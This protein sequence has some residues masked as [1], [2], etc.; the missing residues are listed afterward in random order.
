[1]DGS[2]P[3]FQPAITIYIFIYYILT[4]LRIMYVILA[5][6][7]GDSDMYTIEVKKHLPP[8]LSF[9]RVFIRKANRSQIQSFMDPSPMSR[10]HVFH[11]QALVRVDCSL[12]WQT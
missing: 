12:G 1:M 11:E 5:K 7:I 4:V 8:Q 9:E 6:L 10:V 3:I 2:F